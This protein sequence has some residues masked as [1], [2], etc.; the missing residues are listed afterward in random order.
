MQAT[1]RGQLG[2]I[3]GEKN[4]WEPNSS[5]PTNH[6]ETSRETTCRKQCQE[7][8]NHPD[9]EKIEWRTKATKVTGKLDTTT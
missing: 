7:S 3:I 9:R 8:F 4:E 1:V 2:K 6:K 5:D